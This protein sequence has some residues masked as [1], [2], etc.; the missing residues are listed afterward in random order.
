[1][2]VQ[3]GAGGTDAATITTLTTDRINLENTNNYITRQGINTAASFAINA[4]G[5]IYLHDAYF[6]ANS[7]LHSSRVYLSANCYLY[8]D[9]SDL[10]M[11][12]NGTSYKLT[13]TT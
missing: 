8:T 2:G 13:K 5:N 11:N 1:L 4:V 7:Y 9:G 10:R 3:S 12:L 6:D